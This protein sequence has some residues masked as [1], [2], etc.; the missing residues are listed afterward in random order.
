MKREFVQ[1]NGKEYPAIHEAVYFRSWE[2][3][4]GIPASDITKRDGDTETLDGLLIKGYEM[5]FDKGPNANG[6]VYERTAFDKFVTDYFVANNLNMTV[7]INH[8]GWQNYQSICGRVLYMEVNTVGLYFV[9][10]INRDF[11]EYARL[12]WMLEQ[13]LLQGLSKEG[14]ATDWEYVYNERGEFDHEVVKEMRLLSVSLVSNPANAIPFE[15]VQEIR[16]GLAYV[17]KNIEAQPANTMEAL[18]NNTN[19]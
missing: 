9:V 18:F 7:D 8:E 6:E 5:K 11:L 17:N 16:N 10:Y 14:Y 13:G 2:E 4:S 3:V 12:K 1:I 19:N 15:R